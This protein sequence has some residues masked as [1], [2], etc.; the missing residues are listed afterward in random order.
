MPARRHVS[1]TAGPAMP[2]SRRMTADTGFACRRPTTA[3]N[4]SIDHTPL[5]DS[6]YYAYFEPY[7]WE[8]HLALLGRADASP[9]ARVRDLGAT[10]KA[11][12][13]TSS[14][15][16]RRATDASRC[17]SSRASIRAKRWP[18]GSS[19]A[20][21]N[22]CSTKAIRW[23]GSSRARGPAHRAEHE[24]RRQRARQPA[25]E[26]GRRQSQPRVDGAV[27]GAQSRGLPR[28]RGDAGHRRRRLPRRARR[29]GPAVRLHRR[30]RAAGELFA[31]DGGTGAGRSGRRC[32]SPIRIS[33]RCMAIRR[34]RT[35][36]ST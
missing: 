29:R 24:P 15:W 27:T 32:S 23:R 25:H 14:P 5:R 9:L 22:A 19:K 26:C 4:S 20:C 3:R 11:A 34:T 31:A 6:V 7:S 16:A 30:Q 2:P 17:G 13:S 12:T 35:P 21:S 28:A 36:R 33:R 1:P 10:S 8:R 18:S